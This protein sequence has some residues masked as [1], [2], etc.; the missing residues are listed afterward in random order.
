MHEGRVVALDT[1]RGLR[2]ALGPELVELR[3]A[4]DAPAA[5][6]ALRELG[7]AG[8][9]AFTVGATVT[10]PLHDRAAPAALEAVRAT[11]VPAVS[12]TTRP[13]TLDDVYLRLTGARL[14]A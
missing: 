8:D 14:D 7:A 5:L 10:V 12:V 6:A 4:G 9:D 1:P 2:E 11:G 13:P 3:V